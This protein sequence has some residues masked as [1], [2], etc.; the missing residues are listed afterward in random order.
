MGGVSEISGPKVFPKKFSGP[1]PYG[2]TK[3]SER[4]CTNDGSYE[5]RTID[6]ALQKIP[7]RFYHQ[8]PISQ[9]D[10]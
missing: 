2:P 10:L 3:T 1:N 6:L 5:T 4:I 8:K 7:S 9:Y